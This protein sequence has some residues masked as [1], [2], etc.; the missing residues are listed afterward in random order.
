M[1]LCDYWRGLKVYSV[2]YVKS[3]KTVEYNCNRMLCL[4]SASF[5]PFHKF[6]KD[7]EKIFSS[8]K[9]VTFNSLDMVGSYLFRGEGRVEPQEALLRGDPGPSSFSTEFH[10]SNFHESDNILSITVSIPLKS[11]FLSSCAF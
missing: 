7:D 4:G 5:P 11:S 9:Y 3:L 6:L 8:E 10:A 1:I 2:I